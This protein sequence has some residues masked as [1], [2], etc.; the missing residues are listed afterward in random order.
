MPVNFDS[1]GEPI[2]E[3]ELKGFCKLPIP[4]DLFLDY[5]VD[6]DDHGAFYVYVKYD[7]ENVHPLHTIRKSQRSFRNLDRAVKWAKELG[8]RRISMDLLVA[9]LNH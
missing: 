8:V 5:K 3:R 4:V 6:D 1:A 2:S 9:E 7:K